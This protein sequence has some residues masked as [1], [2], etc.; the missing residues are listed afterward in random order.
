MAR[1]AE[2]EAFKYIKY[3]PV[4]EGALRNRIEEGGWVCRKALITGL[5]MSEV[6][7]ERSENDGFVE[8]HHGL[9]P[10]AEA[11][12]GHFPAGPNAGWVNSDK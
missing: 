10:V 12:I 3:F 9:S 11:R 7:I 5:G 6:F 4:L 2:S 1:A 8:R